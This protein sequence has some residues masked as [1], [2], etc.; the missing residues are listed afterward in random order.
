MLEVLTPEEMRRTDRI[1]IDEM[2]VAG[3]DLMERAGSEVGRVVRDRIGIGGQR[4]AVLCGKGNNGGDG[5][6]AARWLASRGAL[7][8]VFLFCRA[9]DLKGNAAVNFARAR[10]ASIPIREM[11]ER[12]DDASAAPRIR[13]ADVIIDALLGTGFTGVPRGRIADAIE[14]VEGTAAAVVAVDAPSGVNCLTGGVEGRAIR[15]GWTVTLC[16]PK[17]GLF[18]YPGRSFTGEIVTV[19]IG[20]PDEAIAR[21]GARAFLF[22]RDEAARLV[23]PRPRDAHKGHFGRIL[24]AGGSP[25]YTGAPLLAGRAALRSGGGLVTLGLPASLRSLYAARVAELMTFSLAD[26]DG[27]HTAEGAERFLDDPGKFDVL[28]V[29]PGLSRGDD[30][31]GFVDAILARWKGPLVIDADGLH[32]LAG[33]EKRIAKSKADLVLTPHMGEMERLT[34]ASRDEILADRTGFLRARAEELGVT[35]LLKGNPTLVASPDGIVSINTTGNPGMATAGSGD[36]LT[37]VIAAFLGAGLAGPEAARLGVWVHGR[38]GDIAADRKGESGAIAGD[39]IES[40][41]GAIR[42]LERRPA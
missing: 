1:A 36:V 3:L 26:R 25:D 23:R 40:L 4:I 18:L 38:A 30:P 2:G 12:E 28:A 34:G 17:V 5:F 42:P 31:A 15:A 16:R 22:D 24:V 20:A 37:G 39:Q 21:A 11:P 35:L 41:P 8:E 6:V 7:T 10:E 19:P 9:A 14:L 32:G 33:G 13:A 27:L 29:G